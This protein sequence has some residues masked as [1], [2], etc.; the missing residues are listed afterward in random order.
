VRKPQVQQARFMVLKSPDIPSMLV[1]T[2][3]ISNPQE[4]QRLRTPAQQAKLAAAIHRACASIS[5]P[6]PPR[7]R[8]LRSWPAPHAAPRPCVHWRRRRQQLIAGEISRAHRLSVLARREAGLCE[9]CATRGRHAHSDT[10]RGHSSIKSL[11]ARSSSD[12]HPWSRSW[13]KTR[14]MPAR[15]ASRS[16]WSAAAAG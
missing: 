5:T 4:E 13:S 10:P 2:A 9:I 15:G 16:N 7:A 11:P 3:Y 8:G 12:P 6:I 14:S 1:E